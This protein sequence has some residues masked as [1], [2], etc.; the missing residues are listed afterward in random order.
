MNILMVTSEAAPFAKSGGLADAVSALAGA[1]KRLGHDVRVVLPRYYSVDKSGLEALPGP[2]GVPM[3]SGEEW[4]GVY[5]GILPGLDV[6]VYFIEHEAYFGREGLYGSRSESDYSDNPRRFSFFSRAAFQLCRKLGWVPDVFHAHD[7]PTGLVPVYRRFA[8]AGTEFSRSATVFTIH[9]L[10]Y[11]GVYAKE[12]FPYFGLPWE[13]YHGAGLEYHGALNL[14]KT[15]LAS[16]DRLSTVSPSY[17]REIQTPELG[18]GLDGLLRHR[19]ADL[20]G[21]LNGVDTDEWNPATDKRLPARY[22]AADLSGKAQCKAALQKA[23]GL[24]QNPNVPLIGMVTRLADQ[25][26]VGEL[27]GPAHGSAV[28]ICRDMDIQFVVLGSGDAWCEAELRTLSGRLPNFRARIGYSEDLAHL[29]EAGSDFF[30]MP[31]RY[32]PCGLNQMYSL[33]YGTLPIVHRTGG[34]ADTV[35]NYDQD[36]G[37]G[38]GFMFD[39][40]SPRSIY[41]TVGWAVWAYYNKR[42]HVRGMIRRAMAQEFSWDRSAREYE[43]LYSDALAAI[44]R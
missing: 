35:S 43:R 1:L 19:S 27:F 40:L 8:E 6:P 34:L 25:K 7:W 9:N 26:G 41:D 11:Q 33:R 3:G 17:A 13:L 18:Q 21:I 20:V 37:S 44:R 30:L 23:F 15:G 14:L 38:T 22:S 2:L 5:R 12:N 28:P 4:S 16:A 42:E 31:S 39:H 10:G 32:E 36:S 29:V 24:E